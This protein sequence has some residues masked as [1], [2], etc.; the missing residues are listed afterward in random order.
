MSKGTATRRRILDTARALLEDGNVDV[1]MGSIAAAAGVTRQLLY[2]HFDGRADLL[3]E[4]SRL[5]DA[6]VRTGDLQATIDDA[7][8]AASA[9][10]AAVKVQAAIKP[11]ID[12][13][14]AAM[15]RLRAIDPDV[16]AAWDERDEARLERC[17]RVI[18]RLS[19]EQCLAPGWRPEDAARLL[20]SMTSQQAWRE[21]TRAGLS[22]DEWCA[23]TTRALEDTLLA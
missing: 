19:A 22:T 6:E 4:L 20:W 18:L 5:I 3:L 12:A 10:R 8:D 7:S 9:L 13:I 17:G 14:T 1:S 11:R 21:L 2:F 23:M 16:A 15:D